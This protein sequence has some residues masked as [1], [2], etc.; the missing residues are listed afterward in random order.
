MRTPATILACLAALP[1]AAIPAAAQ[2]APDQAP[3]QP[4][5]QTLAKRPTDGKNQTSPSGSK[6]ADDKGRLGETREQHD[7]YLRRNSEDQP[8]TSRTV[9]QGH[10]DDD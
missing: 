1:L 3:K 8:I 10:D 6:A 9:S 2:P 5:G 7:H 4:S